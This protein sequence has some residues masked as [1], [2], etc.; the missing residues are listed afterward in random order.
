MNDDQE[1]LDGKRLPRSNAIR[2][3]IARYRLLDQIPC[4]S[5]Q[6]SSGQKQGISAADQEISAAPL[7]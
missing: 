4:A 5:E 1:S 2:C 3:P 6:G 7:H